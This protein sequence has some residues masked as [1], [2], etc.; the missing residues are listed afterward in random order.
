MPIGK[1]VCP[2]Y[3]TRTEEDM[4]KLTLAG[5]DAMAIARRTSRKITTVRNILNSIQ[6]KQRDIANLKRVNES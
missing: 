4:M 6:E 3:F 1:I 2:I 5:L